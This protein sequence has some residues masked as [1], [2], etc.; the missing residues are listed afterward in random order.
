M[1]VNGD[2]WSMVWEKGKYSKKI[3][4]HENDSNYLWLKIHKYLFYV[5]VETMH[6]NLF[7][8]I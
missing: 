8:S 7:I 5:V 1:V 2:K 4:Q 6:G 3:L